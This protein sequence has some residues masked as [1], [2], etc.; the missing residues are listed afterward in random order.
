MGDLSEAKAGVGRAFST[1]GRPFRGH[2]NLDASA[3]CPP[4][5]IWPC[6]DGFLPQ[7]RALLLYRRRLRCCA[8]VVVP[9]IKHFSHVYLSAVSVT[10]TTALSEMALPIPHFY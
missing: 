4:L 5:S 7:N 3:L 6:F 2:L 1:N 9:L 10:K 8:S